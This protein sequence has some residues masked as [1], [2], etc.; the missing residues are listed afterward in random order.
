VVNYCVKIIDEAKKRGSGER[1][2]E[3]VKEAI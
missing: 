3:R 1:R 2:K